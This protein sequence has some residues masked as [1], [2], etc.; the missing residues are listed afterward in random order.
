M[1]VVVVM[2]YVSLPQS[3]LAEPDS[4]SGPIA[5]VVVVMSSF[6]LSLSLSLFCLDLFQF[7]L[8]TVV[9]TSRCRDF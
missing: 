5:M 9:G 1:V 6:E 7:C 2:N 3:D 4:G 8:F